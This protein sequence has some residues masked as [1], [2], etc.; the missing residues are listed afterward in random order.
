[1]TNIFTNENLPAEVV[2][3]ATDSGRQL[4][5]S[6]GEKANGWNEGDEIPAKKLNWNLDVNA[7]ALDFV[8]KS[9]FG[10]YRIK[11]D[12]LLASA[13]G[14]SVIG[15]VPK[16][17]PSTGIL[18]IYATIFGTT[19]I[20]ESET[21]G[22]TWA[23][24]GIDLPTAFGQATWPRKSFRLTQDGVFVQAGENVSSDICIFYG[25]SGTLSTNDIEDA[26]NFATSIAVARGDGT[27]AS[28]ET[29]IVGTDNGKVWVADSPSD[30]FVQHSLTYSTP[31]RFVEHVGG[32][33]WVAVAADNTTS[34]GD[35]IRTYVSVNDGATWTYL[36]TP[37][38]GD[39]TKNQLI[40]AVV[41]DD[42][43]LIL[44]VAS[45]LA[46]GGSA[47][48][49]I[50][51]SLN[52]SNFTKA[53]MPYTND[54]SSGARLENYDGW[55]ARIGGGVVAFGG[56]IHGAY[57]GSYPLTHLLLTV[58]G[59]DNWVFG[60]RTD[61]TTPTSIS[62]ITHLTWSGKRLLGFGSSTD[63]IGKFIE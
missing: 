59:G 50:Y 53:V 32:A 9:M 29:V 14:G 21:E 23:D 63:L 55:F 5:P 47:P 46:V 44:C 37:T 3:W 4:E 27:A 30:T 52:Y 22:E 12:S 38:S 10:G 6:T 40:D 39:I 51:K 17:V 41:L 20:W 28:G 24:S 2:R 19:N 35:V 61:S 43:T 11:S 1:M 8:F 48:I 57:K 60:S 26:G 56:Q 33:V 42:S 49:D 62:D 58:D 15:C 54:V 34:A 16:P 13:S 7:N 25:T 31:V 18:K 45:Y 36:A